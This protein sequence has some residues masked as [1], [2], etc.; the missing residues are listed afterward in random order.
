MAALTVGGSRLFVKP[1]RQFMYYAAN[2]VDTYARKVAKKIAKIRG[3][4]ES[5][6]PLTESRLRLHTVWFPCMERT[7]LRQ[8]NGKK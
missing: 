6:P 2:D 3:V 1:D 4:V 5:T 8:R 7:S